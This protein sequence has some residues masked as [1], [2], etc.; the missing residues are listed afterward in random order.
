MQPEFK[1]P[2]SKGKIKPV[3]NLIKLAKKRNWDIVNVLYDIKELCFSVE[4]S[5]TRAFPEIRRELR[6]YDKY[7]TII[8]GDCDGGREVVEHLQELK[9]TSQDIIVCGCY[10]DQCVLETLQS[11][12]ELLPK[13]KITAVKKAMQPCY[14]YPTKEYK[15]ISVKFHQ[16]T[17]ISLTL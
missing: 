5:K 3:C 1:S 15:K 9:I 13:I 2:S 7:E 12:R 8:K 16:G 4:A 17:Y 10:A 11:I 14:E 6:G